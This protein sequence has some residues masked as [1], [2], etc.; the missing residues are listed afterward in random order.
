MSTAAQTNPGQSV[1]DFMNVEADSAPVRP[2][3]VAIISDAMPE[4][5][6]VGAY[7]HDPGGPERYP[8]PRS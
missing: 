6:G 2:G 7:Y 5:N 3:R 8:P 1:K 4:R